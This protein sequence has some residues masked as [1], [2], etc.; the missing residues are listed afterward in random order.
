[1]RSRL[2]PSALML[3]AVA[4]PAW[5]AG[6]T[7]PEL[8]PAD[9][10]GAFMVRDL[11]GLRKK[12]DAFIKE[13]DGGTRLW[14]RPSQ[15]VDIALGYVALQ[16]VADE[17]RPM[18]LI[19]ANPQVLGKRDLDDKLLVLAIPFTDK[20]Q[21]ARRFALEEAD[22]KE[23]KVLA[24]EHKNFGRFVYLK[25]SYFYLGEDEKA[26]LSVARGKSFAA[27]LPP[28]RRNELARADLLLHLGPRLWG[29]A[30]ENVLKGAER[31][32]DPKKE[33]EVTRQVLAALHHV[34]YGIVTL[35]VDRGL[36]FGFHTAF[37]DDDKKVVSQFL[38]GLRAGPGTAD[39]KGL[40]TGTV[41]FAEGARGDG[42]KSAG[43]ARAMF[44]VFL[45]ELV[46]TREVVA[47]ADRHNVVAV[48]STI[49]S[50]LRGNRVAVYLT[51]DEKRLGLASAVAILDTADPDKFLSEIKLLARLGDPTALHLDIEGG[52][53]EDLAEVA[54]LIR[55]LGADDF[56]T[57]EEASTKLGLLGEAALPHLKKALESDDAEVRRRAREL[58]ARA[59]GA[60]TQRRK[61]LLSGK[62]KY[63]LRPS[64]TYYPKAEKRLGHRVDVVGVKIDR[65]DEVVVRRLQG[66]F[67]PNWDKIRLAVHGKQ[68]VVLVG[69][70]VGL[71]EQALR[72]L[73]ENKPGLAA[74]PELAGNYKNLDPARKLEFHVALQRSYALLGEIAPGVPALKDPGPELTSFALSIDPDALKL[75]VWIP[76]KECRPVVKAFGG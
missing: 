22:L 1:M 9:A 24:V 29:E 42:S 37:E 71:F 53:K 67:G 11:A 31:A 55:N 38:A 30:W 76:A 21:V 52:N 3:L 72:N 75:D 70:D 13:V 51:D 7:V 65:K 6:P 33:D 69:S 12:G 39:L 19:A 73:E 4:G 20:K 36:G 15:L 60:A 59:E 43:T 57:R 66:L 10:A 64:F 58:I 8:I 28:A 74:A 46:Y 14:G 40:P 48:F 45:R 23:G 56:P 5:A 27:T 35:R 16:G 41:I 63:R 54:R 47:A 17:K 62:F 50:K 49:W 61:D 32:L 25:G 26:V 18:G 44:E 34:R 2:F 68:V